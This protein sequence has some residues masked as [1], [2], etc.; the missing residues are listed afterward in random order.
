MTTSDSVGKFFSRLVTKAG[1]SDP[2]LVLHSLR[3]GGI[4]K[5]TS[6]GVSHNV[7]EMIAGHSSCVHSQVYGHRDNIPLSMLRD[8]SENL[9]YVQVVKALHPL[10]KLTSRT[11]FNG[12]GSI[13]E[14]M[15]YMAFNLVLKE[16]E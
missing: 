14:F 1:L 8:G 10:L 13:S 2:G 9:R 12:P 6:V 4:T 5:L 7:C 15:L 16:V 11:I 3:H